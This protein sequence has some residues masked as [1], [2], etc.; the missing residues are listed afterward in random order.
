M[1][2]WC[3]LSWRA[4]GL[5]LGAAIVLAGCDDRQ[6]L[7]PRSG[8]RPYEVLVVGD[9]SQTV[10][11]ALSTDVKGLPQGEPEF[12]VSSVDSARFT[13]PL[14]VARNIVMVNIDPN[15][16]TATRIRYEKNVFA[17]PQMVVYIGAP[18]AKALQEGITR[19]GPMLR[20]LLNRA[21]INAS[22]GRLK[23]QRN[24]QA[25]AMVRQMFGVDLWIPMD[26]VSSKRGKD[27]LWL[28]N[29]A[30]EGMQNI[31]VYRC[32][33]A[34]DKQQYVMLRD[35]VMRQNIKGE[36]DAMHMRTVPETVVATAAKEK[37]RSITI[38]RGLWEMSG[39]AMGGPFVSHTV[40]KLTVEAFVFAPG[41]K[42]R[43]KLRQIEAAL[44]T[45]K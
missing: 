27:F 32:R 45:L 2:G 8:G 11:R 23:R 41:S 17:K 3:R 14:R 15:V 4:A 36:T 42:K 26:M 24:T 5:L 31:V 44:Y 6:G 21:E 16:Y 34:K 39:D 19:Q 22:I 30:P 12:D 29:N 33:E 10:R 20:N 13:A 18:S 28:S 25:E 40:G 38:Y 7:L 43:N 9:R 35:S 37:G 1:A